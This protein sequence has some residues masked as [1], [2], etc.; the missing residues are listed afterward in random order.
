[1]CC[2]V[3]KPDA[4]RINIP[5]AFI[6]LKNGIDPNDELINEIKALCHELLPTY[7]IPDKFI[8]KSG[9]PRTDRGKVDYKML[10]RMVTNERMD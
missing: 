3:G 6:T 7:M 10:E 9:F 4:E 8:I 2:V 5:V 1:M